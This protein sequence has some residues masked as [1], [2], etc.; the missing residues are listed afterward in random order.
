MITSLDLVELYKTYFKGNSYVLP[1]AAD[2]KTQTPAIIYELDPADRPRGSFDYS[3]KGIAFNKLDSFGYP[4]WFPVEFWKS[5]QLVIE[6]QACT[7]AV[8]LSKQ[9]I[10]TAVSERKGVVI[11]QFN[12]DNYKFSIRGF[13]INKMRL[14]PEAEITAL[15]LLHETTDPV[16][17]HGA[18]PEIFLDESCRVVITSVDFPEVQGKQPWIRPFSLQCESDFI[19]DLI[20][21]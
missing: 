5:N 18:Y 7:V 3:Q 12:T 2:I 8:N 10:R 13:L 17:L 16:S 21:Q 14:V 19:Q 15:K 4:I 11:E 20:I 6:I 9:I 1:N